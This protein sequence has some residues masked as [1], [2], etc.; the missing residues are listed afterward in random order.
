MGEMTMAVQWVLSRPVLNFTIHGF[1]PGDC[2][3]GVGPLEGCHIGATNP[4][5]DIKS[6]P[7]LKEQMEKYW[8]SERNNNHWLWQH[9]W[10]IHGTCLSTVREECPLGKEE[11]PPHIRYFKATLR[12]YEQLDVY[13]ELKN[14]NIIPRM[15]PYS[16]REI[17]SALGRWAHS[18]QLV[19]IKGR[20]IQI[21][22]FRLGKAG[23]EF[24]ER[25]LGVTH[26]CPQKI[27]YY[28]KLTQ[29][30]AAGNPIG[31]YPC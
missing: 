15:E 30:D 9:E 22:S 11:G 17:V 27:G 24:K 23:N 25:K 8:V 14:N 31:A 5:R 2:S 21:H 29:L 12:Q 4:K 7:E 1:W 3:T 19:C 20:L 6:R 18:F 26:K 10:N 16:K 28:P 13:D